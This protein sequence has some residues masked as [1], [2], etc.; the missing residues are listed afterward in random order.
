M[1]NWDRAIVDL[2]EAN[3]RDPELKEKLS[4]RS[5]PLRRAAKARAEADAGRLLDPEPECNRSR[6]SSTSGS[7]PGVGTMGRCEV[8]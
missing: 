7:L 4:R 2:E 1:E 6:F 8:A 3:R 5:P